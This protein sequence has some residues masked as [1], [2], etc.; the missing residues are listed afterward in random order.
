[1]QKGGKHLCVLCI[2]GP[3]QQGERSLQK[4]WSQV[5]VSFGD[6]PQARV[7]GFPVH[8]EGNSANIC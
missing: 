6:C 5:S 1:M 7:K 4:P 2:P 3:L 8:S